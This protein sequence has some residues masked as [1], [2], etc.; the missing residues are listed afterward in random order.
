M[1]QTITDALRGNAELFRAYPIPYTIGLTLVVTVIW[2]KWRLIAKAHE[3]GLRDNFAGW[4]QAGEVS[5]SGVLIMR[6][7]KMRRLG[8]LGIVFWGGG[9]WFM[10]LVA[11]PKPDELLKHWLAVAGSVGFTIM[12]LWILAFSFDRI[13]FDGKRIVRLS[14]LSKPFEAKIDDLEQITPLSK[15]IAGG[16]RLHFTDGRQLKIRARNSGYRQLLESLAGRDLKL[17][18]M[19]SALNRLNDGG[20]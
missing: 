11:E 15:T 10:G 3:K 7:L 12:S 18:M 9:A 14:W 2:F 5:P 6:P 8:V 16:V 4:K 17:R 20:R 19:L 13:L 1:F